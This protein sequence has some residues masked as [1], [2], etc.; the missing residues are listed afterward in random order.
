MLILPT[1]T[2]II[3]FIVFSVYIKANHQAQWIPWISSTV[4]SLISILFGI[5]IAIALFFYQSNVNNIAEKN[6][7]I[8]L[9]GLEL[10][11]IHGHLGDDS[12]AE[13]TMPSGDVINVKLVGIEHEVLRE[14]GLSGLFDEEISFLMLDQSSSIDFYN[15]KT[16]A[17][18]QAINTSSKD[19]AYESRLKWLNKNLSSARVGILTGTRMIA[20]K[21][22]VDIEPTVEY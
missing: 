10:S 9:L 12:Q 17:M 8:K 22:D 14:A 4:G 13:L 16:E 19:P 18:M 2:G 1:L 5:S 15:T 20:E 6:K 11:A 21:L 3:V 7:Y